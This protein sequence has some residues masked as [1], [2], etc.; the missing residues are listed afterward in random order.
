MATYGTVLTFDD[1]V[2]MVQIEANRGKNAQVM[3]AIPGRVNM[4]VRWV[5]RNFNCQHMKTQEVFSIDPD[6]PVDGMLRSYAFPLHLKSIRIIKRIVEQDPVTGHITT[7][8]LTR[9]DP[10]RMPPSGKGDIM[11][12]WPIG[13]KYVRF[14]CYPTEIT[15]FSWVVHYYTGQITDGTTTNFLFHAAT[16]LIVAKSMQLL[17]PFMRDPAVVA[18]YKPMAEEGL[19]TFLAADGAIEDEGGREDLMEYGEI[20][21]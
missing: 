17:A 20:Y 12:W 16:D 4:A 18:L 7:V 6:N 15:N 21:D 1:I 3:A 14:D 13:R 9:T 8:N 5:E 19:Q 10:E 2:E 11:A